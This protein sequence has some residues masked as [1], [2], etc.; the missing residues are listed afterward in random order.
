MLFDAL[1]LEFG[2]FTIKSQP[3]LQFILLSPKVCIFILTYA[4]IIANSHA[5]LG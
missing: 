3:V 5:F 2:I 1:D 4:T